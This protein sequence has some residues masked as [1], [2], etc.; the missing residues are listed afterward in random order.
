MVNYGRELRM[1]AD[2]R[3]KGKVEKAMEFVERMKKVQEEVGVALKKSQKDMKRQVDKGRK[4]SEDWKKEDRVLL[5]TKDLVFKEQLARKL[6]N[7]YVGL[8]TIEEVVSTNAVKL[9]LLISMRIH[10]V[11][12]VSQII[13]YKEQVEGQKKEEVK[14]IKVE[15][16]EECEVEKILN[17]RKIRGVDRY[18]VKWKGFIT[19]SDMW[20]KKKDLEN[21]KK[22]IDEFEERLRM[23]VRRV[24]EVNQK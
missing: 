1:R 24:E 10:L 3:K 20:K 14:P 9:Q 21:M 22:L 13:Q 7:Q 11:V 16:V 19:E 17:K 12:N 8:Y 6:V 2:I 23:E 4:E 5:S 18:L 15:G